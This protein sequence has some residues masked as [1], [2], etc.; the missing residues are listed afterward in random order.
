MIKPSKRSNGTNNQRREEERAGTE[1][2]SS[3]HFSDVDDEVD[4]E[5]DWSVGVVEATRA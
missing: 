3:S 1:R 2:D 4:E 5:A